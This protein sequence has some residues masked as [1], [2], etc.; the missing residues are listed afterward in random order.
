ME[1][2]KIETVEVKTPTGYKIVLKKRL[3]YGEK[4]KADTELYGDMEVGSDAS[5]LKMRIKQFSENVAINVFYHIDSWDVTKDNA[6]LD[7][8]IEN[9][10]N[11]LFEEDITFLTE[12]INK[13]KVD[14]KKEIGS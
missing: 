5:D 11:N 1:R 4:L 7:V 12:E 6:V 13:F 3:T 10:K 9:L 8:T 2:P 14:P